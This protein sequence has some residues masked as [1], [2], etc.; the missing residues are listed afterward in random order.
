[1]GSSGGR[2]G[3]F[4][5]LLLDFPEAAGETLSNKMLDQ[6]GLSLDSAGLFLCSYVYLNYATVNDA[7][8]R[9]LSKSVEKAVPWRRPCVQ[10]FC[11][12]LLN[13]S[14]VEF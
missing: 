11:I 3:C 5:F 7:A 9:K 6:M 4:S 2:E 8:K 1:M 13:V 10:Q 14:K 12:Q